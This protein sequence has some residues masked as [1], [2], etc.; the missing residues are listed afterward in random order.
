MMGTM[1]REESNM[2]M[3]TFLQP[4]GTRKEVAV[5]P[6]ANLMLA[7]T[8][9]GVVG[10]EAECG[11]NCSCATCH[12]YVDP[13]LLGKL[14]APDALEQEMLASIAAEHRATSRLSCQLRATEAL[15]GTTFQVPD[16][17]Y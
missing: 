7:A 12:V 1:L 9:A 14:P 17:Q 16:R 13:S 3:L 6:G 11:G 15:N 8:R 10:I 2:I 5:T 4:D